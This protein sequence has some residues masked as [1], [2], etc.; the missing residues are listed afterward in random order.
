MKKNVLFV[1]FTFV[2]TALLLS[3]DSKKGNSDVTLETEQDSVSYALGMTIGEN[4]KSQ[5]IDIV[6]EAFAK[7]V[8]DLLYDSTIFDNIEKDR[9]M[10]AFQEELR[11]K[12]EE[13]TMMKSGENRKIADEFFAENI[14]KEGVEKTESGLQYKIIEQGTGPH[15]NPT[16]EVTVHYVGKLLDGTIFDSSKDRG[17]PATFPL[18]RV[19][20]GWTE[21]LQ[22]ISKG[23]HA[24]LYIPA[25][26]AYGDRG[27]GEKIP[28]G[29][30]L[31][32]EVELID[33]T[34]AKAS[35]EVQ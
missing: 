21:G 23:G 29:S 1:L 18:N 15:P 35:G 14:K 10:L 24:I 28:G 9:I 13:E 2:I 8:N 3:C 30:A 7:G 19:I 20:S 6:P 33:F 27:A 12:Q 16:D 11:Q 4:F 34:E 25:D 17:Q 26:L 32:F 22:L 31:I 5:S